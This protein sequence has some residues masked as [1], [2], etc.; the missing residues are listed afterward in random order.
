MDRFSPYFT[1]PAEFGITRIRPQ[2]AYSHLYPLEPD[3]V[4]NLAYYFDFDSSSVELA[5]EYARP[6]VRQVNAWRRARFRGQLKGKFRNDALVI[7][8]TRKRHKRSTW[9]LEDP[10]KTGYIFC[11]QIR[12]LSAIKAHLSAC[13]PERLFTDSWL[14]ESLSDLVSRGLML[15]EGNSFLSLAILPL[16]STPS[17]SQASFAVKREEIGVQYLVQLGP[18][19]P[20]D[21]SADPATSVAQSN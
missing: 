2:Q 18:A 16:L 15:R 9:V 10:L 3:A 19:V 1:R 13:F 11:D 8:D 20:A 14:E 21:A 17:D 6:A 7:I 4:V 12:A 5:D